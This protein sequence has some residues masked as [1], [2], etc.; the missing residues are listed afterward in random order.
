MKRKKLSADT[1][2]VIE[3]IETAARNSKT[4]SDAVA[5]ELAVHTEHDDERFAALTALVTSVAN[6]VK[7]LLDSRSFTR[8]VWKAA[9][10]AGGS[11][12]GAVAITTLI[13]SYLRG[14]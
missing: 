10:V 4:V 8:G 14:H 9:S 5:R 13:I 6:D 1:L 3:A 7:S 2:A 11:V 12:G